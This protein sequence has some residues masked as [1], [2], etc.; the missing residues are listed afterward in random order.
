LCTAHSKGKEHD[1]KLF[2]R[3][4]THLAP[5]IKCLGDKGYQGI[6][7]IPNK[8]QRYNDSVKEKTIKK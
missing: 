6:I 2:K 7:V 1:F 5:T 8:N 3:S 4:Q